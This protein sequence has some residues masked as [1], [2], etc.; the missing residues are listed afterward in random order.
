MEPYQ[1][2]PLMAVAAIFQNG[3][4]HLLLDTYLLLYWRGMQVDNERLFT[5]KGPVMLKESYNF[6]N[7]HSSRSISCDKGNKWPNT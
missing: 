2:Q 1:I 6:Q 3:R 4:Q 7:G 5:N